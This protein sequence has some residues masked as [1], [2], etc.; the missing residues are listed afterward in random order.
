MAGD[1][2]L[3]A[4]LAI[5]ITWPLAT[6]L[7]TH[8]TGSD[9]WAGLVTHFETPANIWN[10]W[11]F[12]FAL[13]ELHQSPF[14]GTYTF[15]PIGADLWFHTLAPLPATLGLLLLFA[16]AVA[17]HGTLFQLRPAVGHLTRF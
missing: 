12:R 9:A 7:T 17:L 4:V 14:A 8:A 3:F 10:I 11:W 16:V 13:L 2:V 15:Y 5:A 1:V 6:H